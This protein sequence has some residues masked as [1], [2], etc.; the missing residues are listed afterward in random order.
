MPSP[1]STNYRPSY[2]VTTPTGR[3]ELSD[4]P[5]ETSA[6]S[7]DTGDEG[8][9]NSSAEEAEVDGMVADV[10]QPTKMSNSES[11]DDPASAGVELSQSNV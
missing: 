7:S 9:S 1:D 6:D 11:A 5:S 2:V 3:Q 10:G 4:L 8:K